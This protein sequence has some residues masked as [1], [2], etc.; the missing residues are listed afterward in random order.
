MADVAV[1]WKNYFLSIKSVCP[2]S[3]GAFLRDELLF[4]DWQT[5]QCPK[6]IPEGK[7][8]VVHLAPRH[9]PRQLKK[10]CDRFNQTRPDEEW[11]WSHPSFGYNSTPVACFIQQ[12]RILLEKARN[13][14]NNR[15]NR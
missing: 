8:A 7:Q 13:L 10:M 4:V 11:L 9:N 14:A 6:V 1:D 5:R 2:W 15:D 3:V 12:D